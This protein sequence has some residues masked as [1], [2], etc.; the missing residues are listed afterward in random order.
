MKYV[1]LFLLAVTLLSSCKID[2]DSPSV[3][4]KLTVVDST[5]K[6]SEIYF[7]AYRVDGD[8]VT[9]VARNGFGG[10]SDI[11]KIH[12][13]KNEFPFLFGY[14]GFPYNVVS[15]VSNGFFEMEI[16]TPTGIVTKRFG[17][18]KGM[19]TRKEF[20]TFI[21]ADTVITAY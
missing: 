8:Q 5:V 17:E 14:F 16:H 12:G 4:F 7:N 20:E 11:R 13:F 3:S 21:R 19:S 2:D 1:A 6:F 10:I 18:I 15:N 9:S